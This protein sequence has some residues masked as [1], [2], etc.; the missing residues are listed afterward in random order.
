MIAISSTAQVDPSPLSTQTSLIAREKKFTEIHRQ[1]EQDKAMSRELACMRAMFPDW[2]APIQPGDWFAG[3]PDPMLIGLTTEGLGYYCDR[4]GLEAIRTRPET[5]P[6]ERLEID[7]LLAYWKGRTTSEKCRA[8]FPQHINQGLPS[9][10]FKSGLEISYPLYR[11][12]GP[13]LDFDHLLR[14]GIS[15]LREEVRSRKLKA[16][17]SGE[18]S[19]EFLEMLEESLGIFT[20]TALWYSTQA[21][22]MASAATSPAMQLKMETIAESLEQIAIQPPQT[23]HQAAQL[24]WLYVLMAHPLNYGR[25]DEFLGDFLADDL[26]SGRLTEAEALEML[27]SL[28]RLIIHRGNIWNNR[29]IIGGL[30][31]RN[32][33]NADR[34]ALL[35]MQAQDIVHDILPMLSL[36]W[37]SGMNPQVWRLAMELIAQGNTYPILYNDDVN[38]P[39]VA[40][41]FDIPTAEAEQYLMFGCG[42][43]IIGHSSIGSPNGIINLTKVL[44]VTLHNGIDPFTGRAQGIQTGLFVEHAEFEHLW[45]VYARQVEHQVDLL[46]EAQDIIY[47]VT[48]QEVAFPLASLLMD[49]CLE[50]GKALLQGGI[51]YRGATLETFGN[52]T[53]ADALLAIQKSVYDKRW[54]SAAQLLEMLDRD[55]VGYAAEQRRLKALPKFGNDHP[56]ADEMSLRVNTHALTSIRNQRNRTNL[57]SHLAV[58]INNDMSV[59]L[60]G[61]TSASADGRKTGESLSNGNQPGAG[62]DQQGITALLN[63]MA[64]L[65]AGLHAGAVHNIKF[66]KDLFRN[67]RPEIE[68]L[69]HGY[70]SQGGTQ[71]MITVVDQEELEQAM[72]YPE[73]YSNLIVRIGGY[74]ERFVNLPREIQL[75][76]IERT[77][78]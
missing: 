61:V 74:S 36:R 27:V 18:G 29:I 17:G 2:F 22:Q 43:Y 25:M 75:E 48:G 33:A 69:L 21:R 37:H 66:S 38:I 7:D 5:S 54:F 76:V 24:F 56:E 71:A 65:D 40:R 11:I 46:A 64:K 3:R 41:A 63:S 77:I 15:G 1:H 78:Y 12:A 6:S 35:A 28:W 53:T 14:V 58:L 45:Q 68:A 34:F 31:R 23:F 39:G 49:D 50:R 47:R 73:R 51:R 52:N 9:D 67:H 70:F 72:L 42:E 30:G 20:E 19:L 26:D 57:H 16:A 44:N 8:A 4:D 10:D 59:K 62:C 32:E 60:G 55:F 13:Y